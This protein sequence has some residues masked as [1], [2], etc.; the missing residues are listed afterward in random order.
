MLAAPQSVGK[1]PLCSIL[2]PK[3]GIEPRKNFMLLKFHGAGLRPT[4]YRARHALSQRSGLNRRPTPYHGVAL[5][6]SYAGNLPGSLLTGLAQNRCSL[7]VCECTTSS[8]KQQSAKAKRRRTPCPAPN[9]FWCGVPL[10]YLGS[11]SP[12]LAGLRKSK[13]GGKLL[14]RSGYL[15]QNRQVG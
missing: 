15:C 8:Y 12:R 1:K 5:P 11:P 7:F 10:N 2:E 9:L 14:Y 6:L 13:H 4:P 3:V